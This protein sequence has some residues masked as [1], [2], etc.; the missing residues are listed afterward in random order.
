[1][2]CISLK[3]FEHLHFLGLPPAAHQHF[4]KNTH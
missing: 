4:L 3:E 2:L 1:L